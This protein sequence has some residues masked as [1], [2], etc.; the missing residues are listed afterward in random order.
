MITNRWFKLLVIFLIWFYAGF[1]TH[2]QAGEGIDVKGGKSM[3][4]SGK[5]KTLILYQSKYGSTRQY[6]RW[7]N[8]EI[9]SDMMDVEKSDKYEF[10]EY[11]VIVFGS[12]IRIGRIA[13]A[14]LIIEKWNALKGKKVILFTTSGTPPQHPNI[15]KMYNSSLPEEIR[16]E[17]KYF[18]LRG[19]ILRKDLSFFDKLLIA[20]G[21]IMEKDEAIRN[22]M[23]GE[24]DEVKQESLLPAL[25]YIKELSPGKGQ[26]F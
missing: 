16:K 24:F 25:K 3:N 9:P 23:S 13:I 11:D 20:I 19:R 7:I 15:L 14:P 22:S 6:A 26:G 1:C 10:A 2:A 4:E 18:P 8:D 5:I 21:R 12:Y 17:I